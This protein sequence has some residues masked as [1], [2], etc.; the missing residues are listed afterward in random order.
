MKKDSN[1]KLGERIKRARL[2]ANLTQVELHNQTG[3]SITQI[4]NYENG[5][6]NIGI[7]NLSLI[8]KTTGKTLDELYLGALPERP[9]LSSKSRGELIIN[10]VDALLEERI[11]GLTPKEIVDDHFE[12]RLVYDLNF[13]DGACL[14]I[15]DDF[16]KKIDDLENNKEN[17]S[18]PAEIKKQFKEAAAKK[19]AK[20]L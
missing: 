15:I 7:E 19:I 18:D 13:I 1:K 20:Y 10:C 3:I 16:A 12:P 8:A 14:E 4:S 11:I 6:R 17:Y 5:L 2:D 9:I